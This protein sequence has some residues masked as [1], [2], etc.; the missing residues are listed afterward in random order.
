MS[1]PGRK[2]RRSE[3]FPPAII[4][5]KYPRS[6]G[7]TVKESVDECREVGAKIRAGELGDSAARAELSDIEKNLNQALNRDYEDR[8]LRWTRFLVCKGKHYC[9]APGFWKFLTCRVGKTSGDVEFGPEEHVFFPIAIDLD[10]PGLRICALDLSGRKMRWPPPT[11]SEAGLCDASARF[12]LAHAYHGYMHMSVDGLTSTLKIDRDLL[13]K[14]FWNTENRRIS[15][16]DVQVWKIIAALRWNRWNAGGVTKKDR[17]AELEAMG[18]SVSPKPF[19]DLMSWEKGAR[20][21]DIP[22]K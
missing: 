16:P 20:L 21:P 12:A 10:A 5:V 9:S 7:S 3:Q 17:I 19:S 2:P 4:E 13:G 18:F 15:S 6:T 11:V 8:Q 14:V 1:N 22:R